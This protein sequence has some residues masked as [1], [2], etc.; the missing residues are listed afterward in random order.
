MYVDEILHFITCVKDK[1][2]TI[3]DISQGIET[4]EIALAI[5]KS[6]KNNKVISLE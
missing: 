3:N 2:N 6:S 5:L 1:K 4:L